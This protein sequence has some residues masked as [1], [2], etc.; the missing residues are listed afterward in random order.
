MYVVISQLALSPALQPPE[1]PYRSVVTQSAL[2]QD[3]HESVTITQ[4]SHPVASKTPPQP[5]GP[6]TPSQ[7]VGPV[8][9]S[10]PDGPVTPQPITSITNGPVASQSLGETVVQPAPVTPVVD[11]SEDV[12]IDPDEVIRKYPRLNSVAHAGRLAVRLATESY[13]G[14]KVLRNCTVYGQKGQGALP[15]EKL[16][17]LKKKLAIHYKFYDSVEFEPIWSKCV[18]AINHRASALRI[19]K[20]IALIDLS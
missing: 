18:G 9:P 11:N 13:F 2:Q 10:Q 7:P 6:V 8:T 5:V 1:T 12:L 20:P 15:K 16:T 4:P 19:K 17:A 3:Y 14:D